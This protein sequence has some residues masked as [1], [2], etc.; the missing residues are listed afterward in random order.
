MCGPGEHAE[1]QHAACCLY[2]SDQYMTKSYKYGLQVI[3]Q[4]TFSSQG[5]RKLTCLSGTG[6]PAFVLKSLTSC[7]HRCVQH[8]AT[9]L[10]F[11]R[12]HSSQ[13]R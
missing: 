11:Q 3:K 8:N 2:L 9:H 6:F 10:E 5:L 1:L 4:T 13:Q 12:V 7:S